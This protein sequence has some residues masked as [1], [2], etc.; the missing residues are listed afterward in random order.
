MLIFLT[1]MITLY[2]YRL[3]H[4]AYVIGVRWLEGDNFL[5]YLKNMELCRDYVKS[6]KKC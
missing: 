2:N 5:L 1:S 6:N 3:M 4:C